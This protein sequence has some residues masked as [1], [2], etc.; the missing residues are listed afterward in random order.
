M[1]SGTKLALATIMLGHLAC[2]A[3][4]SSPKSSSSGDTSSFTPAP[5]ASDDAATPSE[6][7]ASPASPDGATS[8]SPD[9]GTTVGQGDAA[10]SGIPAWSGFY[11]V[12]DISTTTGVPTN[13]I[14]CNRDD[15]YVNAQLGSIVYIGAYAQ[16]VEM[17]VYV[18]QANGVEAGNSW[19]LLDESDIGSTSTP[20]SIGDG[21]PQVETFDGQYL[22]STF[23]YAITETPDIGKEDITIAYAPTA[24]G[25]QITT[26]DEVG[27]Q[28]TCVLTPSSNPSDA[29]VPPQEF[30]NTN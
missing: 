24:S 1:K 17:S 22:G 30:G 20:P 8:A 12:A 27:G 3:G 21:T 26:V 19:Q 25:L 18:A 14:L 10:E 15:S 4:G 7:A 9:A 5:A 11:V 23:Q 28:T 16:D 29:G 2:S 6:D 13:L